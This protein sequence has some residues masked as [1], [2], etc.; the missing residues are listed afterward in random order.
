MER[1][2]PAHSGFAQRCTPR[3]KDSAKNH[4]NSPFACAI[5]T[6]TWDDFR[7]DEVAKL[8]CLATAV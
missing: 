2:R 5:D 1:F 6:A 7:H 4:P 3:E 8:T